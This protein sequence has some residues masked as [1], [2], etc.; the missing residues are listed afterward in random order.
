MLELYCDAGTEDAVGCPSRAF[1]ALT[2]KR[3]CGGKTTIEDR[4][5][6]RQ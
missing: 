5:A 4:F 6:A 3:D 1:F 2:D